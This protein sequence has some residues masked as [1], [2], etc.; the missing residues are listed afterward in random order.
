MNHC[1]AIAQYIGRPQSRA[2]ELEKPKGFSNANICRL[3]ESHCCWPVAPL[4]AV[5]PA[6]A[7]RYNRVMGKPR[8]A[9]P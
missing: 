7:N 8:C 4:A 3:P 2:P 6:I 1:G 5:A 9:N